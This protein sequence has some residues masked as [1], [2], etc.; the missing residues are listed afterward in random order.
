MQAA[1]QQQKQNGPRV[2][3]S[4]S[5]SQASP[6]LAISNRY[7]KLLEFPVTCTKQTAGA[8]SNRYKNHVSRAA[9]LGGAEN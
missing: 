6:I 1:T 5:K 3:F 8:N 2:T 4:N 7:S 9:I